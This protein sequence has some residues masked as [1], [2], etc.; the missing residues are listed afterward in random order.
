[1]SYQKR[2]G[3][4]R[5]PQGSGGRLGAEVAAAGLDGQSLAGSFAWSKTSRAPFGI[6]VLATRWSAPATH[7][8]IVLLSFIFSKCKKEIN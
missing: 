4:A 8:C 5:L 1:M 6:P 7:D 2:D 3:P